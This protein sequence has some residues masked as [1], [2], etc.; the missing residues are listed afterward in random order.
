MKARL[1]DDVIS[2]RAKERNVS[3]EYVLM[4]VM[5]KYEA[6]MYGALSDWDEIEDISKAVLREVLPFKSCEEAYVFVMNVVIA[7]DT[8]VISV[9]RTFSDDRRL[10]YF[11]N[12]MIMQLLEIPE[13][14]E[15]LAAEEKVDPD[16]KMMMRGLVYYRIV[17]RPI[18]EYFLSCD[19]CY[20]GFEYF[21]AG[22]HLGLVPP[23][24]PLAQYD[25]NSPY[26]WIFSD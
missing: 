2:S 4:R 22:R 5:K 19:D 23:R 13:Y 21:K 9:N 24:K 1:A 20:F 6:H 26:P 12:E 3:K 10:A 18:R 11:V 14:A 16:D 25:L 8:V 17:D 15:K 7:Y